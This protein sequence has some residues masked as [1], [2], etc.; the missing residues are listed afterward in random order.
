MCVVIIIFLDIY[1]YNMGTT[2]Y[3][4]YDWYEDPRTGQHT[5]QASDW[6]RLSLSIFDK[7]F[8]A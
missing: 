3:L 5:P 1:I 4:W 2:V 7:T 8:E 6:S